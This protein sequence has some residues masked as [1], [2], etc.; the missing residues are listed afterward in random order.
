MRTAESGFGSLLPPT[1]ISLS[2]FLFKYILGFSPSLG[3]RI[4][5]LAFSFILAVQA[6]F[7][8]FKA[9][10]LLMILVNILRFCKVIS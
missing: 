6:F 10:R 9:M 2:T 7:R 3:I 4:F 1:T 8:L 5:I